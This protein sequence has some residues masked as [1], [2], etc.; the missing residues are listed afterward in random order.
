MP[1]K[2]GHRLADAEPTVPTITV[3]AAAAGAMTRRAR[4]RARMPSDWQVL[5]PDFMSSSL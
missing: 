5:R 2:I 1:M 3:S 4:R